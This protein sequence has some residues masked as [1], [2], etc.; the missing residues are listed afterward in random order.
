[1]PYEEVLSI[2]YPRGRDPLWNAPLGPEPVARTG[3]GAFG[4]FRAPRHWLSLRTTSAKNRFVVLRL[5][6]DAQAK[7]A[8]TLLEERTG[9]H[10]QTAGSADGK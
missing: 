4:I 8:I 10:A 7:R 2:S 9:R 3:G 1:V 5:G 6:N